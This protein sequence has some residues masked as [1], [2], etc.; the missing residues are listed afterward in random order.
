M[1]RTRLLLVEDDS[2]H[3]RLLLRAL[4]EGRPTVDIKLV[5]GADAFLDAVSQERFS[6]IV[7]D[8]NLGPDTATELLERAAASLNQTPVI[9]ISSSSDQSVVIESMRRGVAD[10]VPK[11]DAVRPGYLWKSIEHAVSRTRGVERERRRTERRLRELRHAADRDQLTGLWNRR[12]ASRLFANRRT[13]Q[14]DGLRAVLMIDIDRFK[15]VN[16][17]FGHDAGDQVLKH[18]ARE[19]Q[20][21][22]TDNEAVIRWGGEEFLV[23]K[24]VPDAVEAWIW[25][26]RVRRRIQDSRASAEQPTLNVTVSV[27]VAL[28]IGDGRAEDGLR[29]ADE[30][31]YLAKKH[32][33]N[34][35]CTARMAEMLRLADMVGDFDQLSPFQR[36]HEFRNA[37][38]DS[39]GA[40]QREHVGPHSQL[41]RRIALSIAGA[42]KDKPVHLDILELAAEAHDIGKVGIPEHLLAKASALSPDEKRFI[43]EHARFGAE[44]AERLRLPREVIDIINDHHVRFDQA[45][46]RAAV[47]VQDES[48]CV[49]GRGGGGE[50][51]DGRAPTACSIVSL[52]D[53]FAAMAQDRPYARRRSV[54]QILSELRRERGGQFDPDVVETVHF[55][56]HAPLLEPSESSLLAA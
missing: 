47:S 51:R 32:G 56:D 42:M 33:R 19:L 20:A 41:V 24:E 48:A 9:V 54:S 35:V 53:A 38:S 25:A 31:L 36:F 13:D 11:H 27:G 2:D 45:S 21:A 22:A 40:V 29:Q 16:D 50:G 1:T 26:D 43:D 12:Y 23:V 7:M 5:D 18:V 14:P 4:V 10:Y 17:R 46:A 37:A 49:A 55:V 39:L 15:S 6:C 30:A 34:R 28:D 44:I 52:A 8:Y 3:Q